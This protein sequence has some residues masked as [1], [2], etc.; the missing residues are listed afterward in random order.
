LHYRPH[1]LTLGQRSLIFQHL[2]RAMHI[3]MQV[4][5]AGR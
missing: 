2:L 1:L 4:A 5:S 3:F